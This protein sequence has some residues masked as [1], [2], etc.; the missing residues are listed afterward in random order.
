MADEECWED[1]DS[2]PYIPQVENRKIIRKTPPRMTKSQKSAFYEAERQRWE[3][4]RNESNKSSTSSCN[5]L[6]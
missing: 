3:R 6:Q 5:G 4:L 2:A 1:M